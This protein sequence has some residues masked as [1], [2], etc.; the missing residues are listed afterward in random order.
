MLTEK[1]PK[2]HLYSTANTNCS[3]NPFASHCHLAVWTGGL[4]AAS[5][6]GDL[7]ALRREIM[8][9]LWGR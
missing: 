4:P 1:P 6:T 8:T 3:N 5:V 9:N 7:P 2:P